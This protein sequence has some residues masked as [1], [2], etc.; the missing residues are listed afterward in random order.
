MA[1]NSLNKVREEMD[2]YRVFQKDQ[3]R[4]SHQFRPI[5]HSFK[6]KQVQNE[7][8]TQPP[9]CQICK[10]FHFGKCVRGV[11]WCFLCQKEGHMARDC[12][13]KNAQVQRKSIGRVYTLDEKKA[14][15]N[16][17]LIVGT[18][19]LNDPPCFVLFN[20]GG[21]HPFVLMQCI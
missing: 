10:R 6:G 21:T 7:K 8:F 17:K 5:H 15:G 3:G 14:K 1:E 2:Q 9:Q 13:Q 12:P 11:F 18:C 16:N 20:C 19:H 4:P